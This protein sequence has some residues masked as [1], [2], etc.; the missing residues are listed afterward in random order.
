MGSEEGEV[1]EAIGAAACALEGPTVAEGDLEMMQPEPSPRVGI[2]GLN[3]S[4]SIWRVV[5]LTTAG[6]A[7]A[8][9]RGTAELPAPCVRASAP[10]AAAA[11]TTLP[12]AIAIKIERSNGLPPPA[13]GD[14]AH[15]PAN[16][17]QP[18]RRATGGG[19]DEEGERGPKVGPSRGRDPRYRSQAHKERNQRIT[20]RPGE[21]RVR[22]SN[23][24]R[25]SRDRPYRRVPG[26]AR[27]GRAP[28]RG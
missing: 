20:G 2:G 15:A 25:G 6:S 5:T 22:G 24:P 17:D 10:S 11:A 3:W 16:R 27:T 14:S 12:Q 26:R 1:V 21:P 9:I 28:R 7:P 18:F 13:R 19:P 8:T 23:G 4:R